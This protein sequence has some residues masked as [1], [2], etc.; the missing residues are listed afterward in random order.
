M[1]DPVAMLKRDHREVAAMLKTLAD[2]KPG[3]RRQATVKKLSSALQLHMRIEEQDVYPLVAK[4]VGEEEAEE[5]NIEHGLARDGIT[6]MEELV[7]EPGFGAA[8]A[9][10]TAGI[11][12]H[13]KEEETEIFPE[14][15]RNLDRIELA[16]LGDQIAQGEEGRECEN[17]LK[18][19]CSSLRRCYWAML[20]YPTVWLPP[21]S[22]A[23]QSV[24]VPMRTGTNRFVAVPSPT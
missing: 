20:R 3:A 1:N 6:K 2:S 17:P 15:K 16:D 18:F 24:A 5:A 8:V 7:S 4:E 12:H 11:K 9:M 21:P 23:H 19:G 14:L 10:L 13:V 22:T